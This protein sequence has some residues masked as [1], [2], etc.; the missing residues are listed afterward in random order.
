M[1]LYYHKTD[2]GAEY[3]STAH[4]DGMDEGTFEGVIMRTDG[5]NLILYVDA[6][7]AEG[8]HLVMSNRWAKDE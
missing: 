7:E 8:I 4:I 5:D 3:H 1:R 6:I 2:G